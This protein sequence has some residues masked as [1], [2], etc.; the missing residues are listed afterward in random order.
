MNNIINFPKSDRETD[1]EDHKETAQILSLK[2]HKHRIETPSQRQDHDT[3]HPSQ[4]RPQ[5]DHKEV[6]GLR[7]LGR[8]HLLPGQSFEEAMWEQFGRRVKLS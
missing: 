8:L 7:Y 5:G 2:S 3:L 4:E 6:S 1:S